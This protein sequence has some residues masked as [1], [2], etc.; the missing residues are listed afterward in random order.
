[1]R[2]PHASVYYALVS[3]SGL[4]EGYLVAKQYRSIADTIVQ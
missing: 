3:V 4:V 1:M 2:Q